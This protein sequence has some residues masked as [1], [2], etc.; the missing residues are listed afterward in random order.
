MNT[1]LEAAEAQEVGRD[2]LGQDS[3]PQITSEGCVIGV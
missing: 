2:V 3:E 1:Q